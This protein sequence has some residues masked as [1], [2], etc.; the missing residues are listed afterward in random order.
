M[1][2]R[3]FDIIFSLVILVLSMPLFLI[4]SLLIKLSSSGPVIFKQ[5][6]VGKDGKI[7]NLLKFRTMRQVSGPTITSAEDKRITKIGKFLRRTK[8]DELPQFI[9]V[10]KRDLSMVGPRPEVSVI[11]R[12][13]NEEQKKILSFKPGITSLASLRFRSEEEMLSSDHVLE[14]Y[15]KEILPLKI[16]CD[17]EYFKNCNLWSDLVIIVKT[18]RSVFY[19]KD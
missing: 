9:N 1:R 3:L 13:Y 16:R 18:I 6:R 12:T 15:V 4:A 11:V 5:E 10:L 7:F 2:K 14:D 19:V 8:I 17:L